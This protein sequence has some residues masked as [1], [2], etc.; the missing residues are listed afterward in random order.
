MSK[1]S[2]GVMYFLGTLCLIVSIL[3][4]FGGCECKEEGVQGLIYH[5]GMLIAKTSCDYDLQFEINPKTVLVQSIS[6]EYGSRFT[7]AKYQYANDGHYRV[8]RKACQF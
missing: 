8:E 1:E 4:M 5:E 2:K 6:R 7:R 3:G